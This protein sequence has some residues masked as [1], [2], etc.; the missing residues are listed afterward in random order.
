VGRGHF[1]IAYPFP[2]LLLLPAVFLSGAT[3]LVYEIVWTRHLSL[4]LGTTT[5]AAAAVL[6]SFMLGLALG[7]VIV[8]RRADRSRRPLRWCGLLELGI[9]LFA[10]AF[11]SLL[12]LV[13]GSVL[14]ACGLLVIPAALMGG[15]LPVLARAAADTTERGTRAMGALYGVNTLGAVAGALLATFVLMESYGLAG[16]AHIAAVVNIVLGLGFLAVGYLAGERTLFESQKGGWT[17]DAEPLVVVVFFLAGFAG[18]ALEMAWMRLLVYF[19]EGFTIAFGLMLATYLL[20]LGAGA[21]GGTFAAVV[22]TNPRRVLGRILLVEGILALATFLLMGSVSGSLESMRGAYV[23]A[24]AM[25]TGY[26]FGLFWASMAIIFPATF[27]AGML[28]PV[29]ARI[30]LSDREAIGRQTGVVYAASTA[31][32]VIAPGVAGFWLI[33]SLGVPGT[34]AAMAALLLLGGTV[35]ALGRGIKEWGVAGAAA[36]VFVAIG[37]SA[38]LDTPLIERSH[39]FLNAPTPRRLVAF[40]EGRMGGVSVVEE[41]RDGTRRLYIDGFSAAETG[42]QYGYM[43]MLGHLPVLLHPEPKNVLVIAFGTGTTAGAVAA[44]EEVETVDCVEIEPAVYGV[45]DRFAKQNRNVLESPKANA[46]VADGREYVRRG[47]NRYDVI[48]LEPLMPYTPAAVYLYTREFYE[49]ARTSLAARGMLCQWIPPQGVSAADMKRLVASIAAVFEHVSLWYFEHAVLVLASETAP[50][51]STDAFVR[52]CMQP[53]V[54][55]DLRRARVGDPAH[56]FGAHVCSGSMLREALAGVEPMVDDRTDL[57]FR[58]LPRRFGKRSQT[59][60]AENL[61]FLASLHQGKVAWIEGILPGS[62][63]VLAGGNAVLETLALEMRRR[64]E[65]GAIVPSSDL[66]EVVAA[67]K[68][69]LFALSIVHRRMYV[70]LME[71]EFYDEAAQLTYAPDR[72]V[73]YLALAR[74]AEGARRIYYL[75]LA[76]RQNGLLEPAI[77]RELGE[78]LDGPQRR[79]CLNRARI[80]EGKSIEDGP[81]ALPHVQVPELRAALDSGRIAAAREALDE[82]RRADLGDQVEAQAREW[83]EAQ[84]DKRKAFKVLQK[85]GSNYILRAA[86]K[87][88]RTGEVEDLVT[89]APYF[90]SIYPDN[91]YWETLCR[92]RLP[93]LREA[94]AY[95]ARE[96]GNRAHLPALAILCRDEEESV[97][98]GAFLAFRGIEPDAGKVGYDPRMPADNALEALD[99]LALNVEAAAD[100]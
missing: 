66:R 20:G 48:T 50:T 53:E 55:A 30:A 86:L 23:E 83:W 51:V 54:L 98:Q 27:C 92:H 25:D 40:E 17:G 56:L 35:L 81:E 63:P 45:A 39:V 31:G 65:R 2:L 70:E 71:R 44:H 33:P 41:W 90:S 5:E 69:A 96:A 29:V 68:G 97:R 32:A 9:G 74:E 59:Y 93:A 52:R 4:L 10:L 21:L 3:A 76:V 84:E 73:A 11:P 100:R 94:A 77:L 18:L 72:S 24:D 87:L 19:L 80:Q 36:A 91:R 60:H 85:I 46:I 61:E 67:D 62:G 57:E 34:I 38:D 28:M 1:K 43:R 58:P 89:I 15:T 49:E 12:G 64:V 79:Y 26:A 14:G 75:T 99:K 16:A 37:L 78:A 88:R 7:A 42:R 8:G 22:A 82:A 6:S 13:G 47:G 95:A